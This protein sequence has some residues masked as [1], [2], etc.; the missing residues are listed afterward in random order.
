MAIKSFDRRSFI[1]NAGISAAAF[2]FLGNLD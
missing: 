1:K 2:P